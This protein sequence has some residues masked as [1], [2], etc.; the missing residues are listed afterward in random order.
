MH[1]HCPFAQRYAIEV[2]EAFDFR[3]HLGEADYAFLMEVLESILKAKEFEVPAPLRVI[4]DQ[5]V[6]R[7]GM[8]N[9][10]PVGGTKEDLT[11][12]LMQN[13]RAF[14]AFDLASGYRQ[15][16][17]AR[18]NQRLARLIREKGLRI[19]LG[20]ETSFD[21]VIAGKDKTNAVRTLLKLGVQ[22]VTFLG[23]ALFEGGNDGVILEFIRDWA[24][25]RECPLTAIRV[26]DWEDTIEVCR[27]HGWLE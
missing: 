4:G 10:A 12:E 18:L 5:I 11:E 25:P 2:V 24:G 7:G 15:T 22:R 14:A 23:D 3:R 13:R 6:P 21:F 17:L 20:G 19:T 26:E 8:L 16:I 9:F 1:Y 27:Q